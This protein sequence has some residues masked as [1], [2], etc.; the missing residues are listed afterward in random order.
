MKNTIALA[1]DDRVVVSPH[2]GDMGSARSLLVFEQVIADL[3]ALYGVQAE[4]IVCDA[5]P[6]Y[7][8]ARWAQRRGLPLHP[9]FHHHAHASAVAGEYPGDGPWQ[10]FT[11]DGVGYGEDG[12]LWGG[13]ALLG[14]PGA[15]RRVGTMRPFYLFGGERAGR[16]PWRSAAALAWEAGL[17]WSDCPED[18]PLAHAAWQRRLNAPKTSAVGRLFDAAAAFTGL[19]T[20]ASFEGHGPMYLEAACAGLEP[21]LDLPLAK[22]AEGMWQTDWAP[23]L[24]YLMDK[25]HSVK[26]RAGGFHA[27]LAQALLAQAR[28]IRAE[29]EV[30]RVGLTGGVFQNRV[31]TELVIEALQG[32][33]FVVHT[34]LALPVNDGGL[35]FGQMI[36]AGSTF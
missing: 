26:Q 6:D 17:A 22:N 3:Q 29:H 7:A 34:P 20:H 1:W 8:T 19:C 11:W 23:L 9:V 35:S 14:R 33:G 31:L 4:R 27:S 24:P 13:E 21:S 18:V 12:S 5:H 15:W 32:A 28:A 16:E 10:V 36:E 25:R 30:T 2:I